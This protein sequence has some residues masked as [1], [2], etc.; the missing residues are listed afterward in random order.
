MLNPADSG[1]QEQPFP[2]LSRALK[3]GEDEA[4][5]T[6]ETEKGSFW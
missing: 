3:E 2:E 4:R 1:S 5:A 6:R